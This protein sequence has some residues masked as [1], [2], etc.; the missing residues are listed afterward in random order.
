MN[1]MNS[2]ADKGKN[3][4]LNG[5]QWYL[6]ETIRAI[7]QGIGR[8]IRTPD[9]FGT[10]Y[11][12]DSRFARQDIEAQIASWAKMNLIKPNTYE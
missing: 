11:L 3:S 7:N 9:D 6:A 4:T 12:L 10:V 5:T 8:L 2:L 1:Y